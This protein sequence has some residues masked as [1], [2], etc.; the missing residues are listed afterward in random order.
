MTD[1]LGFQKNKMI[2]G[3]GGGG[4]VMKLVR[5]RGGNIASTQLDEIWKTT[6]CF[7]Q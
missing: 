2:L 1:E 3:G 5:G 7:S 6:S 4:V